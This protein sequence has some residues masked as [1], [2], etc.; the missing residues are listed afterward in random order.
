MTGLTVLTTIPLAWT[1]PQPQIGLLAAMIC[2]LAAGSAVAAIPSEPPNIVSTPFTHP[3]RRRHFVFGLGVGLGIGLGVGLGIGVRLGV[4]LG[5]GVVLMLGV[6]ARQE[7]RASLG[8]LD[9]IRNDSLAGLVLGLAFGLASGL[10]FGLASGLAFGLASGL[11]GG[12]AGGLMM[13]GSA[14]RRYAVF[15]LCSRRRL[16]FR[17]G[18]F[19]DWAVTA[20][21]MRYSGPAYQ[22]RHRELQH[23]LRRHPTPVP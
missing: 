1:A 16:P 5:I 14:S 3:E 21:L 10:T 8:P 20:G 9:V 23:W 7:P 4:V 15:L 17:L 22:Y 18:L 6:T 12:L 13:G 19:L 11:A 2:V